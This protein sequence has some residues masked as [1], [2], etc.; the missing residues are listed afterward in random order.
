MHGY[1]SEHHSYGENEEQAGDHAEDMAAQMLGSTLGIDFDPNQSWDEKEQVFK[2]SG[3]FV[4]TLN[5]TQTA[6]GDKNGL[7]TSVVACA[8]LILPYMVERGPLAQ[9]AGPKSAP[10]P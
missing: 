2:M 1:L 5:A 4:R 10:A 7:W 3:K 6:L 8:V 9:N